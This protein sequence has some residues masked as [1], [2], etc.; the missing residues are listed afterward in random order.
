MS[1]F[2]HQC[3][4]Q[5]WKGCPEKCK[6]ANIYLNYIFF[7]L[8]FSWR[9]PVKGLKHLVAFLIN[10]FMIHWF[11]GLNRDIRQSWRA[12]MGQDRLFRGRAGERRSLGIKDKKCLGPWPWN[13][14]SK[15]CTTWGL[16]SWPFATDMQRGSLEL[17]PGLFIDSSEG[18]S[19][20]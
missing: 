12:I 7:D 4:H 19:F 13:L 2:R 8:F 20:I 1:D 9:C 10:V 16:N 3:V 15:S 18:N 14:P 17:K 6:S 11:S 5:K